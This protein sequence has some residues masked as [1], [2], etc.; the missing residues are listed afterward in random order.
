MQFNYIIFLFFATLFFLIWHFAKS[1][2]TFK[3]IFLII[4]SFFFYGW[5][6]WRFVFLLVFIG[7]I[8]YFVAIGITCFSKYKKLLLI[9]SLFSNIGVLLLF[10]Y[11]GFISKN[12][13]L[14]FETT[15]N[16][17]INNFFL[18]IPVGISFYTFQGVSYTIDVY[19]GKF[20]PTKNV[21]QFFAYLSMF[22]HLI[23]G[24]IIRAKDMLPQLI[25][26]RQLLKEDRW[27]GF[28][29]IV[30]GCFKK[31][32]IADNLLPIVATAFN[33][34]IVPESSAF[35]WGA[36]I[37][38]AVQ[39]YCEF[40]GYSD[41]ARGLARWMGYNIPDNFNHPY[42][43]TSLR[44][45]WGR[46]NISLSTWFRDYVYIPLGGNKKN[47]YLSH[48]N[49]WI[50]MVISGLW[51]GFSLTYVVWGFLHA[52]FLSIERI[53]KWP[54]HKNPNKFIKFVAWMFVTLE[55]LVAWVF[56]RANTVQQALDILKVMF[57]FKGESFLGW[58]LN[59]FIFIFVIILREIIV[60]TGIEKRVKLRGT[61][62][63][64]AEML[65][66]AILI[67]LIIFFRG[68]G[69]EFILSYRI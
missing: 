42:T 17:K 10:K 23:A 27:D 14:L 4:A 54:T 32:V 49:M 28:R 19:N 20:K 38:F 13:D 33:N 3:L 5:W 55:I 69:S 22:P 6:D 68:N 11:S 65:L 7:L 30:K 44:E 2:I 47:K 63:D 52:L 34:S 1:N 50:T 41:I 60:Y 43:S 25:V 18:I 26:Q 24:P 39:I 40:S 66:Y 57:S 45:F 8:D 64:F 59:G 62:G 15:L 12:I 58:G 56:F 9:S 67:A 53:L 35:W 36:V 48:I 21:F 16:S 46:W 61:I 51:L 31:M 29:L 37:V